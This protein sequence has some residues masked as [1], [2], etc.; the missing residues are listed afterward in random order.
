MNEKATHTPGPWRVMKHDA[1]RYTFHVDAGPAGY[2]RNRVAIV[3][4]DSARDCAEANAILLASAPDLLEALEDC[5]WMV[6]D[7]DP[8]AYAKA[9]AAIAKARGEKGGVL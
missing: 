5:A 9:R 6:K 8:E 7:K 2:E 3:S 1:L 4:G